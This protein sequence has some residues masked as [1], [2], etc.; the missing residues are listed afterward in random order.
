MAVVCSSLRGEE[1]S[2]FE[3]GKKFS[4]WQWGQEGRVAG[5]KAMCKDSG[6]QPKDTGKLLKD[7]ALFRCYEF[8]DTMT[9]VFY[10]CCDK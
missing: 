9:L 7:I 3:S 6:L 5:S 4:W 10:G 1:C 8:Y 2:P